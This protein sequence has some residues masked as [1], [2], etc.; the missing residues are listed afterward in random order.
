MSVLSEKEFHA[1]LEAFGFSAACIPFGNGH[2]N[3]TYIIDT[4]PKC[5][6][7]RI[8][9]DVFKDPVSLMDN[10]VAVTEFIT[11]RTAQSPL[12]RGITA[13]KRPRPAV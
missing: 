8:N 2:I 9:K 3:D 11:A 4:A 6:L 1:V 13:C 12:I 5:V 10:V 7:Q